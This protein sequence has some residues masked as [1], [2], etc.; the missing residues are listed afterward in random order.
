MLRRRA[1]RGRRR[2][3]A[4]AGPH[5]LSADFRAWVIENALAGVPRLTLIR[6]LIEGGVPPRLACA[7][8]DALLASPAL[9]VAAAFHR[10][11]DQL[12]LLARLLREAG[13]QDTRGG[14]I[15]RRPTITAD[16]FFDHH[17][18]RS[19]PVVLTAFLEDWP[20]RARWSPEDFRAR[21]GDVE[22]EIMD[23]RDADP[24]PDRN[25]EAHRRAVRLGDYVDRITTAGATNDAYMVAHNKALQ[26][27]ALRA[28]LDDLRP[29]ADMFDPARI[30]GGVSLWLG[31]AGTRTPLHHDT[32]NNLFCQLHGRKRFQL[33]SPLETALLEGARGFYAGVR[34]DEIGATPGLS[35]I[36]VHEVELGPGEALFLPAGWWHEVTAL[37]VSISASVMHFRRPNDISWYRPGAVSAAAPGAGPRGG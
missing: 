30:A 12:E 13:L 3:G 2:L 1:R 32:T 35:G 22:I 8:V 16:E 26:R 23:G 25:F 27:T 36:T 21:F 19:R 7:E 14:A 15:E 9:P 31:P 33:V 28:L 29:P 34:A 6:T 4:A 24:E 10:R 17:F 5:A 11:A 18:A 37:S 20:A